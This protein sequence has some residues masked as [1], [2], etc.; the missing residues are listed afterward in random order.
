ME[1]QSR[2]Q[3]T[4]ESIAAHNAV[5]LPKL[6]AVIKAFN[7]NRDDPVARKNFYETLDYYILKE[8]N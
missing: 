6:N 8:T 5:M 2:P 3:V 1:K 4:D 7:E